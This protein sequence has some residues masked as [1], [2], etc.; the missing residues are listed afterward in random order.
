MKFNEIKKIDIGG[1]LLEYYWPEDEENFCIWL[2]V[3]I[4]IKNEEGSNNYNLMV[5]TPDWLKNNLNSN[6]VQ[7]GRHILIINKFN[8]DLIRREIEKKLFELLNQFHDEDDISFSEK[9]GRYA[10]WEFEDYKC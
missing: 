8:S 3:S 5:C 2:T 4:G 10:H 6:S 1:D 9:I 7:W